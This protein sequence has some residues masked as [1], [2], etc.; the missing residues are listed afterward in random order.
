MACRNLNKAEQAADYI[1]QKAKNAERV[2]ALA[3]KQLDLSSLAS[4]RQCAH[5]ILQEEQN[6][7]ILINNAGMFLFIYFFPSCS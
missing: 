3:I 4:V 1:Q 2:G 7:H 5:E 6:I